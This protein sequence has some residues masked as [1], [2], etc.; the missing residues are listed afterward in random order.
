LA[1]RGYA[2]LGEEDQYMV[3]SGTLPVNGYA[4]SRQTELQSEN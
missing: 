1:R 4:V 2:I 3:Y